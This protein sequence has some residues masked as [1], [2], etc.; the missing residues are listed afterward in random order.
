MVIYEWHALPPLI[1]CWNFQHRK[2]I[3]KSDKVKN[4]ETFETNSAV[5][6][7]N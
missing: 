7:R 2:L 3:V 1:I 5:N 6:F 4:I